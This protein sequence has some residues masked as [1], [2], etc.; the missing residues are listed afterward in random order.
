[1]LPYPLLE[2]YLVNEFT[3]NLRVLVIDVNGLSPAYLT[4]S[5]EQT[6][7]NFIISCIIDFII[8]SRRFD[9]PLFN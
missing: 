3:K 4:K 9:D 2:I 6:D 8:Q 1:M 5:I 7:N